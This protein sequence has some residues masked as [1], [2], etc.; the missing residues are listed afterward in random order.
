V[1]GSS[2]LKSANAALVRAIRLDLKAGADPDRAVQQQ[3]YMKSDLPYY[4]L[5][6]PQV[7]AITKA[8]LREFP[9]T[10][11]AQLEATVRLLFD[12]ATHREEWYSALDVWRAKTVAQWRVPASLPLIKH[13][14]LTAQW[15]DVVDE[16][17]GHLLSPML[18]QFPEPVTPKVLTWSR[19]DNLWLRRVAVL[20][21]LGAKDDLDVDLLEEV[22]D[23]NLDRREFFLRKAVGWALRDASA[24]HPDWVRHYAVTHA[25]RLSPLSTKE[26]TRRLPPD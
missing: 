16:V 26:A 6:L 13:V 2:D 20:S 7:R 4:G 5:T 3:A 25:D 15:W 8:R 10:S 9:V 14:V 17:A 23:P 22:L 19:A 18:R 12:E 1:S 21:Q 11:R 24:R